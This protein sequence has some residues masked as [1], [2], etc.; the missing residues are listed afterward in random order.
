MRKGLERQPVVAA[1]AAVMVMLAAAGDSG[2]ATATGTPVTIPVIASLTGSGAYLAHQEVAAVQIYEKV[3]NDAGG[4]GGRPVHFE[5]VDD[6]TSPQVALAQ[7]NRIVATHPA[8]VLGPSIQSTCYAVAPVVMASGPVDYCASPGDLPPKG[9]YIF[10]ASAS[11]D[12]IV[13]TMVRYGRLRF[14]KRFAMLALTDASGQSSD[15]NVA[16]ALQR[17]ENRDLRLVLHEHFAPGDISVAAQIARIKAADADFLFV[18]ATGTPFGTVLRGVVDAGLT[19]PIITSAANMTLTIFKPFGTSLPAPVA[20]NAPRYWGLTPERAGPLRAAIGEYHAAYRAAGADPT[21]NDHYLWD[22]ARIVV[23]ALRKL[24]PD[25]T[26]QQ[27][28]D[29]LLDLHGFPGILGVYD[30]RIGDQHGLGDDATIMVH[31]NA[32]KESFEPASG[33]GGSP[34]QETR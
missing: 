2:A 12:H 25:A 6:Q 15:K 8:V 10:A 19:L 31:Y 14:G 27:L 11:T 26:A 29:Y 33:P 3:A 34:L 28:R 13:P 7:M 16:A 17:P 18:S 22:P 24:G 9:G 21:P 23:A 32:Q 5:I 1:F 20:F 30:F 4:I